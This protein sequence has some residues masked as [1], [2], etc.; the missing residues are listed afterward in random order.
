MIDTAE[1]ILKGIDDGSIVDELSTPLSA[2]EVDALIESAKT[3]PGA[4][5]EKEIIARMAATR[6]ADLP[7]FMRLRQRLKDA[8]ISMAELDKAIEGVSTVEAADDASDGAQG[9]PITFPRIDPWTEPVD[10]ATLLDEIEMQIKRYVMLS[11]EAAVAL[12]LWIVHAYCFR[13]FSISPRLGIVSPEK[14]CGKTTLL[15]VIEALVPKS[16]MAANVTVAAVFRTIEKYRPTFLIDEADTFLPDN[17]ELRGIINSGHRSD[18]QVIRLV[19]DDHDPRAF[20]TCCPTAIA[21]IGSLPGTIEDRAVKITMR[22]RMGAETIE[23]F[24]SDRVDGLHSLKRKAARWVADNEQVLRDADPDMPEGLDDR[25]RDNYRPLL[26]I[27]DVAGW[28]WPGQARWAAETLSKQGTDQDEQSQGVLLLG[29]IRVV[30][31]DRQTRRGKH[32]DRM[33]STDLAEALANLPDRPWANWARGKGITPNS[34]ARRL[35]FFGI[36]PNTIKLSDG[37]QPNGYKRSQFDDAFARYLPLPTGSPVQSSPSSP[38]SAS[39]RASGQSP[40]SPRGASGEVG[41]SS[42]SLE[43]QGRGEDGE[44]S[45]PASDLS[46]GMGDEDDVTAELFDQIMR[47]TH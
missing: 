16:L 46:D 14:R 21:A 43:E 11:P 20:A 42:Q 27:A 40:G 47:R 5:F 15:S 37:K 24:R 34:V 9:R 30:W 10:V 12:A 17:E 31:A 44:D 19:G 22:R 38:T 6:H 35:R 3:D 18:G 7:A 45:A 26:A 41:N 39:P 29:D 33:S 23:R 13:L 32:A 8:K 25:A 1:D 36:V 2:A 4:P 28:D